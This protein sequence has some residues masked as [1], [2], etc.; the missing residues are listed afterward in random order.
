MQKVLYIVGP[1]GVGK[2]DLAF[3]LAQRYGG[4]LISADS[5][6]VYRSLDII[7]GKDIS[8]DAQ[9][10]PLPDLQKNGI[11]TGYFTYNNIRISLLDVVE[12]TFSFTVNHFQSIALPMIEKI[13]KDGFL[14]IIVGGT[15]LYIS[16][17]LYGIAT[18][19]IEP[20]LELRKSLDEMD[21]VDV[22]KLVPQEKLQS[23]NRSDLHNKRRLIRAIEVS[24]V[25]RDEKDFAPPKGFENLVIGLWCD[26]QILRKRID[27]RVED[28]LKNGAM[29]EMESLFE[30]YG[31]LSS[32]VK[33]ANGYKQL[34]SY[35]K[36]EI[37]LDEAINRW[38]ISEYRHAKNQMTWFR[39]YGNVV[40]FD[41]E[42]PE[43][44]PKIEEKVSKFIQQ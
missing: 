27:S 12:P 33:N 14:P 26:R 30:N 34:F 24:K 4:E 23:M 42:E 3:K 7:S 18:S 13:L 21:V 5:V 31:E 40:W 10:S 35:L 22:Q 41:V 15:G 39:K 29:D 11:R 16:S 8:K 25:T 44:V 28:R 1:T 9:F 37:T 17:L 19:P 38:K 20:D 6:Q 2:T 32:Q 36:K 43:F